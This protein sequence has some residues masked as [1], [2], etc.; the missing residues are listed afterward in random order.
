MDGDGKA[1]FAICTETGTSVGAT[2][3]DIR[4]YH[5]LLTVFTSDGNDAYRVVWTQRIRD[6]R[7]GGN[8]MIIADANNDGRNELCIA[9]SPN[10]YLL[11]YEGG[12]YRP[13]WYHSATATSNPIV[14]D[15]NADGLN[16]LLFNSDNALTVF[17]TPI[18]SSSQLR[19]PLRAPWGLMAKPINEN[20]VH[21][22]WKSAG[23]S[24]TYILYRG[25]RLDSL[26]QIGK[27]IQGTAFTD[28]GLTAEQTYWY[29]LASQDSNGNVSK[30]S[31]LTSVV[32]T[33][34]PRLHAAEYSPPNQLLL[35]FSKPMGVSATHAG[36]YRLHKQENIEG[37]SDGYAPTS[38]ILDRSQRRVVLTFSP[39]VFET[40]SRYEIEALQLS[41]IYGAELEDTG[42]TLT[43]TLPAPRLAETIVYPNPVE[44]NQVTFDK[45]PIGTHIYIYD[46]AGNCIASFDR[47][48]R[49]RDKKVWHL[50]GISSGV[51]VYV[52]ES[53]TDRRVGK[54]S[55]IR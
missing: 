24:A 23:A 50:S 34:R 30:Q 6:I 12:R 41:D 9:V 10:F 7:D 25:E 55:V 22:S 45:L 31:M 40:G 53:E 19:N 18:V 49:E 29:A 48:V 21:L 39:V 3:L 1:E 33:R 47:T 4:Y 20:S 8:G 42:R 5:W 38:A 16:A 44:C 54:L 32:P 27:G 37:R 17:E 46:V 35:Q 26:K 11:Q 13:I 2:P 28:T 51:Y 36:R 15:V 14:A 43:I 52:L